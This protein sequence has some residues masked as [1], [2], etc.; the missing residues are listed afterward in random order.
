MNKISQNMQNALLEYIAEVDKEN[1]ST[2]YLDALIDVSG[3]TGYHEMTIRDV[4]R[5]L[6]SQGHIK[7]YA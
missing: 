2:I 6:V 3:E 7:V 5:N 1:G 4:I